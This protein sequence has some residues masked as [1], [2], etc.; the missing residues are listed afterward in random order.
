M[1]R[2]RRFVLSVTIAAALLVGGRAVAQPNPSTEDERACWRI[3]S[4][5]AE[6]WNHGDAKALAADFATDGEFIT[7][8]G[9]VA[10]GR[11][12]FV[13]CQTERFRRIPKDRRLWIKLRSMRELGTLG[14]VVDTDHEISTDGKPGAPGNEAERTVERR[15]R[16]RYVFT[17]AEG[18][19]WIAGLQETEVKE[20]A[21]SR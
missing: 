7:S 2:P 16:I 9:S 11:D 20:A 4:A 3:V 8:D 13:K 15:L 12:E 5:Q 21:C 6:S 18:C 19:W 17:K 10:V 14:M 1:W